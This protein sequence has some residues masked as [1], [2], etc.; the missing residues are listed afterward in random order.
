MHYAV[1]DQITLTAV[2][3]VWTWK[4]VVNIL[5]KTHIINLTIKSK[6]NMENVSLITLSLRQ[7]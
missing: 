5:N 3:N 1:E 2:H 6:L 7:F 4:V